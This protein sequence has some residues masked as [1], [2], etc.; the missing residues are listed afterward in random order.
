VKKKQIKVGILYG[1]LF[2]GNMGCNALTYS[3]IHILERVAES[4]DVEFSYVLS[5]NRI[6]DNSLIPHDLGAGKVKVIGGFY[7]SLKDWTKCILKG[8]LG[9]TVKERSILDS[10][11]ICFCTTN[12]DSFSDIYG[13]RFYRIAKTI[14]Y[15]ISKSKPV[16]MLP[17]TIGPFKDKK[18]H[19]RAVKVLKRTS[20]IFT[21]DSLS[22]KL[23]RELVPNVKTYESVDMAFFMKYTKQTRHNGKIK[24]GINPSGLLWNGGYTQNNQ[25]KLKESYPDLVRHVVKYFSDFNNVQIVLIGHV[26]AGPYFDYIEDDYRVCKLLKYEYPDCIVAPYFYSPIEAKSYISGLDF[27][28]GSRMHCCIAAYSSGVPIF[29]L[30]YSRKFTG[31]FNDSLDYGYL[32]DLTVDEADHVISKLDKAYQNRENILKEMPRRLTIVDNCGK[33]L[34]SNLSQVVSDLLHV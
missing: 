25:F 28:A 10:L 27:V 1:P 15:P 24:V 16:I 31:L 19:S 4:L 30:A 7:R 17:Q 18:A 14:E 23:V 11:D 2:L 5:E 33:V 26:L 9:Q 6:T 12:G 3:A 22:T 20:A 13:P 8:Q 29:P 21:R 32:S 34:I